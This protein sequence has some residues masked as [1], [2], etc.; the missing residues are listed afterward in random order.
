MNNKSYFVVGIY[1]L[2]PDEYRETLYVGNDG[3]KAKSFCVD[4]NMHTLEM[5][6]WAEGCLLQ[7]YKKTDIHQWVLEFDKMAYLQ[8]KFNDAKEELDKQEE[9]INKLKLIIGE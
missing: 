2:K 5:E 7:R 9:E 3:D 1:D 6:V 4:E 8:K